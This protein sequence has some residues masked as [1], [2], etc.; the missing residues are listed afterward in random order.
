VILRLSQNL[1]TKIKTVHPLRQLVVRFVDVASAHFRVD[2]QI[3]AAV[4]NAATPMRTN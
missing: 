1:S 4:Y 3:P 2:A